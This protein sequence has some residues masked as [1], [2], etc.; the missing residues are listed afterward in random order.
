MKNTTQI[1]FKGSNVTK[2]NTPKL[3]ALIANIIIYSVP[4]VSTIL[5]ASPYG[6]PKLLEFI[7]LIWANVAIM[8]KGVSKFFGVEI[9]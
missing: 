3:L 1:T 9:K 7:G 4:V 8:V 2:T 5:L 6:D